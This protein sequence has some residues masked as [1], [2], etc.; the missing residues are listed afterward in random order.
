MGEKWLEEVATSSLF[1][2]LSMH[3]LFSNSLG[4]HNSL[5]CFL[6]LFV[7]EYFLAMEEESES[8]EEEDMN[9]YLLCAMGRIG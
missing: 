3:E 8:E 6:L 9:V 2:Y 5:A 7:L 1:L 4:W